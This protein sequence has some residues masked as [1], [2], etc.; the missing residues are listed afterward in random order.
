MKLQILNLFLNL[1]PRVRR[2]EIKSKITIKIKTDFVTALVLLL[3]LGW[4]G[5]GI[6]LGAQTPAPAPAPQSDP[7]LQLMLT[8]PP[9]DITTNVAARVELDPPSIAVGESATYRVTLNAVSDSIRWPG[10]IYAPMALTLKPSAR[11]QILQPGP[12]SLQPSTTLNH[13]VTATTPGEY[14]IPAFQ[15]RVYDQMVTVPAARLEV[16]PAG[17]PAKFPPPARLYVELD[18]TNVFAGQPFTVRVL[19]PPGPGNSIQ[20]LTQVQLNGDGLLVDA[21]T[22][23]QRIQP[24]E[25][26]GHTGPTLIYEVTVIPLVAGRIELT[27]QAYTAGNRFSGQITIQGQATIS[28]GL[29]AFVLLDS[30]PVDLNVDPLPR[31]GM[32]SGFNGAIGQFELGAVQLNVASNQLRVGDPLK[33]LVTF[34]S[35]GEIKRLNPPAPPAVTNWQLFPPVAEGNTVVA[36]A[37]NRV[38]SGAN[39]SYTLIPLTNDMVAT[40]AIPFSYFDPQ[41]KEY[42][43]LTI[44]PVPVRI[45]A[46]TATAEA[47]GLALAATA[48]PEGAEKRQLSALA[49]QPGR[50]GSGWKPVQLRGGFWLGQLVPA[51]GFAGV[52]WWDRRRRY[53]EQHPDEVR[54]RHARRELRRARRALTAAA[55]AGDAAEFQ[56]RAVGALRVAVAPH[57]PATPRALVGRDILEL[58]SDGDRAGTPGTVVRRLFAATDAAKF[59]FEAAEAGHLLDL[60]PELER[61]LEQLEARLK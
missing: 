34:R 3:V 40:P 37:P 30:D 43:D 29:T 27:A 24:R 36:V 47:Q 2:G 60:Q 52:W 57:F 39:F 46:G 1:N 16:R 32:Q 48:L 12:G 61:I 35:P 4:A 58:F 53:F 21:G 42:V 22:I 45:A 56:V 31:V 25:F 44:P 38:L 9:I 51:F 54:R 13:R 55:R 23:R 11:A 14:E 17:A 49:K 6:L 8:Q 20:A 7:L 15:V 28:G 33:L 19:L 50:R 41:R 10:D 5:S 59:G 18:E 26:R